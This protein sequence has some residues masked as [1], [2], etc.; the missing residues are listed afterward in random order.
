[1]CSEQSRHLHTTES[2]SVLSALMIVTDDECLNND[3][4]TIGYQARTVGMQKN[5]KR[6]Q[7][8]GMNVCENSCGEVLVNKCV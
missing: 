3:L 4:N 7:K 1:M 8:H 5:T 6:I 2:S